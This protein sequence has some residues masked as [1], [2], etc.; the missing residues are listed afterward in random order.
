VLKALSA[1]SQ[2]SAT[3]AENGETTATVAEFGDSAL[4]ATVRTGFKKTQ[5]ML[6][7]RLGL[8]SQHNPTIWIYL[9]A[10]LSTN[11]SKSKSNQVSK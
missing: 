8:L 2:K 11:K 5:V 10:N 3:V 4:P 7:L 6:N 9:L 1:L